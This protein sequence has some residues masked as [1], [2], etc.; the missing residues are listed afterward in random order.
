MTT[1]D[2]KAFS[3]KVKIPG[4]KVPKLEISAN[5]KVWKSC[6]FKMRGLKPI[7]ELENNDPQR[8]THNLILIDP[9]KLVVDKLNQ[10]QKEF[11]ERYC[12][13]TLCPTLYEV[14]LHYDN[15][16]ASDIFRAV[17]P[18]DAE[19]VTSF[20]QIGHI[21][22]LNLKPES[23]PYKTLIGEV[24]I[25]KISAVRTVV[26]KLNAIDNTYRNFQMEL[27]AGE[28]NFV[29]KTKE[30][31]CTFELDFSKVYWNSRL[32]TEHQRVVE[33]IPAHSVVYDV[34]AG[35][36]PF[37]VPLAKRKHCLVWA[38]DLNPYSFEYLNKNFEL[39]KVKLSTVKTFN[40]DGRDF[41]KT[42]L[43]PDLVERIKKLSGHRC[44]KSISFEKETSDDKESELHETSCRSFI[45]MNLPA[46]AVEFLSEF[47]SLLHDLPEDLRSAEVLDR[48]LPEVLCYAFTPKTDPEEELKPR[49]QL[50][51]S[52]PLPS[53]YSCRVVRNVAPNKEMVCLSFKLWPDLVLGKTEQT[54]YCFDKE[55]AYSDSQCESE[56]EPKRIKCDV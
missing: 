44:N 12:L 9:E 14:D 28:D 18:S 37:S 15:W 55:T 10:Q 5:Q 31:N 33:Y 19:N 11:F 30:H 43:K 26:N 27:L 36:G 54:K 7:A 17:L 51:L 49:A 40:M 25:D 46:I 4:I 22:H 3:T 56:P 24:L 16:S 21:A 6:V 41:I 32:S 47:N 23:L 20:S 34:F 8:E 52:H 38:N 39:N 13:N 48:A 45:I 50:F 29:T 2:R 42:V 35:I 53:N 1:L